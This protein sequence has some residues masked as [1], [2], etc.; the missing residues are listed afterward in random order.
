[1]F[2]ILNK[3][4]PYMSLVKNLG[5]WIKA[6]KNLGRG[7]VSFLVLAKH[8]KVGEG[9]GFFLF[10]LGEG[11]LFNPQPPLTPHLNQSNL[12]DNKQVSP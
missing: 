7:R 10:Q 5:E 3:S 11:S 2:Q 6:K 9:S 4:H 8:F 12:L 1:M